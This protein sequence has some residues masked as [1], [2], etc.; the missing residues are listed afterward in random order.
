MLHLFQALHLVCTA[1]RGTKESAAELARCQ[2]MEFCFRVFSTTKKKKAEHQKQACM[3]AQRDWLAPEPAASRGW[4]TLETWFSRG[5]CPWHPL[6]CHEALSVTCERSKPT[7]WTAACHWTR[8]LREASVNSWCGRTQLPQS[9]VTGFSFLTLLSVPALAWLIPNTREQNT[10]AP[11][12]LMLHWVMG[13]LQMASWCATTST[14]QV[15]ECSKTVA[16]TSYKELL[17][18]FIYQANKSRQGERVI[19]AGVFRLSLKGDGN[20]TL[21]SS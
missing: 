16:E 14:K 7:T 20:E 2:G 9:A 4:L 13:L 17:E 15:T 1:G 6:C 21:Q 3:G 18:A 11:F 8:F 12:S 10:A 19:W 5:A